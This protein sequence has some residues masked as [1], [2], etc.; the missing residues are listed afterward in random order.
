MRANRSRV[1]V[2][3][4]RPIAAPTDEQPAFYRRSTTPANA[5]PKPMH[6]VAT[7]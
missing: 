5:C 6:I 1:D 2:P 4:E 3:V 7:P